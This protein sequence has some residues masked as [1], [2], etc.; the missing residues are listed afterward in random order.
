ME[1]YECN[2]WIFNPKNQ[3]IV[4]QDGDV[5]QLPARICAC[6]Q[7]LIEAHETV[8]YDELLL[9]VWGTIHRDSSTISSVISELRKIIGCGNNGIKLIQTI[10]KKGYRFIGDVRVID[11]KAQNNNINANSSQINNVK[12]NIVPI[13]NIVLDNKTPDNTITWLRIFKN[14]KFL[15]LFFLGVI[16]SISYALIGLNISSKD[17]LIPTPPYFSTFEVMTH[18]EGLELDFDVSNDANWL[19][20]SHED[21]ESKQKKIFV[22]DLI[23]GEIQALPFEDMSHYESPSFSRDATKIVYLKDTKEAC[24]VWLIHINGL[25]FDPSSRKKISE[26]GLSG[27]WTTTSFSKD[28]NFIYFSRS[29]SLTEPFRIYKHNLKTGYERSLTAPSSSGRGDYSFSLSPD[30]TRLAIIRNKLW[31]STVILVKNIK[32]GS[33]NLITELPYLL[34]RVAWYSD[35]ELIYRGMNWQLYLHD[36]ENNSTSIIA[37]IV[38]PVYFPVVANNRLFTYKGLSKKI[39]IWFLK[40]NSDEQFTLAKGINSP[41]IDFNATPGTNGIIY[42]LSNRSAIQQ[43]W[44]KEGKNHTKISNAL[45]PLNIENLYYSVLHHALFGLSDKRIFKFDVENENLQWL[46]DDNKNILNLSMSEDDNSLFYSVDKNEQWFIES[47]NLSNLDVTKFPFNGFSA[48]KL[49]DQVYFT[50]YRKSGLW[51]FNLT[52]GTI[53]QVK[54]DFDALSSSYWDIYAD[55]LILTSKD[56]V[57]IYSLSNTKIIEQSIKLNGYVRNIQ[58]SDLIKGCF[59]DID[60]AGSTEIIELK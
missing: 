46:S 43:V 58:C 45:L 57:Q 40:E 50:R 54:A 48:H 19:V 21:R 18:E 39:D 28:S 8:F 2:N 6:L 55:K 51:R 60:I 52:T 35:N 12:E 56:M 9:K 32:D 33:I 38:Q 34:E 59:L 7:T 14:Y 22:K 44:R 47:I 1:I 31:H 3:E 27:F 16:V 25:T 42:F 30:G 23:T 20:Y 37:N 29:S 24:E 10:P 36:I 53:V 4:Y 5:L 15:F 13:N 17:T 26:C 49:N 11:I 41:Y